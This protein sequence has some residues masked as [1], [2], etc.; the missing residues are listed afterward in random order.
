MKRIFSLLFALLIVPAAALAEGELALF[1]GHYGILFNS[2][3]SG[4]T[5]GDLNNDGLVD[6]VVDV[7]GAYGFYVAYAYPNGA[8]APPV[9]HPTVENV[10]SIA[11]IHLNADTY[12]DIVVGTDDGMLVFLNDGYGSFPSSSHYPNPW[13]FEGLVGVDYDGDSDLDCVALGYSRLFFYANDGEG[14]LVLTDS[15]PYAFGGNQGLVT[16]D[17]NT[18]TYPDLAFSGYERDSVYVLLHNGSN[19]YLPAVP[20]ASGDNPTKLILADVDNDNR[21]D[22]IVG[23]RLTTEFR[24]LTGNSDGSFDP[25]SAYVAGTDPMAIAAGDF[26]SD[27]WTDLAIA[28]FQAQ[29][30]TIMHNNQDGTFALAGWFDNE[31]AVAVDAGYF[32]GDTHLDLAVTA[33]DGYLR[34]LFGDGTGDFPDVTACRTDKPVYGYSTVD[35]DADSDIDVVYTNRDDRSLNV[36]RNNGSGSFSVPDVTTITNALPD[37]LCMADVTNSNGVDAI[38]AD[39]D[40]DT[41]YVLFNDGSGAFSL[42]DHLATGDK[43]IRPVAAHLNGD[44]FLDLAVAN[45]NGNSISVFI[46]NQDGSF[47]D[48]TDYPV[49][50]DPR[51]VTVLDADGDD[52]LDLVVASR[53]YPDPSVDI[54]INDGSGVFSDGASIPLDGRYPEN[55]FALDHDGDSDLDLF[56]L[57]EE[58]T[59]MVFTNQGMGNFAGPEWI[60]IPV[61]G[62]A[63]SADDV[64]KDGDLD[65]ALAHGYYF[66]TLLGNNGDGTFGP[67][68]T[69]YTGDPTYGIALADVTGDDW[70]DMLTFPGDYTYDSSICVFVNQQQQIPL[71]VDDDPDQLPAT[72]SLG[73]Y[74]NPFNAS[75]TIAF[76]LPNRSLVRLD[77]FNVL[78]QKVRTLVDGMLSAGEH[79]TTWNGQADGGRTAPTGLYFYRLVVDGT[80]ETRKALL[81]K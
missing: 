39:G 51:A 20:Y 34:V 47:A 29:R 54:L 73:A 53:T 66:A 44:S 24:V 12:L 65:L 38:V 10:Y 30:L 17:F 60:P 9:L 28:C 52:D 70:P 41:L 81:L 56:V 58:D 50:E 75:Q 32:D 18:D 45:S 72:F 40:R 13:D 19:G 69:W 80:K 64:D 3:V 16:A 57:I 14:A 79:R 76:T 49:R 26:D 6:L 23:N 77:V 7:D 5:S 63:L 2:G 42:T 15:I 25:A 31:Y 4:V 43:P 78:G 67:P 35:V 68:M 21:A 46:N 61:D 8:F 48:R 36:L 27:G 74:P 59:V 22:I 71:G 1:S 37:D 62:Y 55:V 11:L 33:D